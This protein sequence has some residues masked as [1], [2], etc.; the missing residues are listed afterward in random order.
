MVSVCQMEPENVVRWTCTPEYISK[1][2]KG[3]KKVDNFYKKHADI[4]AIPISSILN[5]VTTYQIFPD[6]LKIAK[7]V[8]L[9]SRTIFSLDF[10]PKIIEDVINQNINKTLPPEDE[11]QMAYQKRRS[12]ELCVAIG[13]HRVEMK[14]KHSRECCI[15]VDFDCKKAFDS[16]NWSTVITKFQE[17]TGCGKLIYN[18]LDKR[19]YIFEGRLGF[20]DEKMGRGTP[21]GTILGPS[22]FSMF[23]STDRSMNLS[24]S[25]WVWP[26][27]FS[28][29]KSPIGSMELYRN[30][31]FQRGLDGTYNWSRENFI[32]YHL[33]GK[34]RPKFFV[35]RNFSCS[36][37]QLDDVHLKMGDTVIERAYSKRQLGIQMRFFQDHEL[38]NDYGYELE[39]KTKT[40]LSLFSSRLQDLRFIWEPKFIRTAVHSYVVGNINYAAA[41]QWLRATRHDIGTVRFQYCKALSAIIGCTA[42]E[43]IG[44]QCCKL[45]SLSESSENFLKLCKMVNMPTIKD[46][47]IKSAKRLIEQWLIYEPDLFV[48]T[49]SLRQ[50]RI[51]RVKA[52][53]GTLL[54]DLFKLSQQPV[55]I[56]YPEY[57]KAKVK[58]QLGK[59]DDVYQPEWEDLLK[60]CTTQAYLVY[61]DMLQTQPGRLEQL[62]GFWIVCKSRFKCLEPTDRYKKRLDLVKCASKRPA[63]EVGSSASTRRHVKRRHVEIEIVIDCETE[64]P[65]RGSRLCKTKCRIC[66]YAISKKDGKLKIKY[67]CCENFAHRECWDYQGRNLG[68]RCSNIRHL[69]RKDRKTKEKKATVKAS[70][71]DAGKVENIVCSLCEENIPIGIKDGKAEEH[72]LRFCKAVPVTLGSKRSELF[73]IKR[74]I[75][76]SIL[77]SPCASKKRKFTSE[78]NS[79]INRQSTRPGPGRVLGAGG[80]P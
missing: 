67:P 34:K 62:R 30:G 76:V 79:E 5:V 60:K 72:L 73:V 44:L 54:W 10:W 16:T 55:N 63:C 49:R 2:I 18:Y 41:L 31:D 21:P 8:L 46:I 43:I 56:W 74:L 19:T 40:P 78:E 45:K 69:L 37:E 32:E 36:D 52:A 13:L 71:P 7:L 66:G 22:L 53:R 15:N 24:S 4:L 20:R 50:K 64:A 14:L 25:A 23:Q 51:S 9:P 77:L 61:A 65:N 42:P 35:F 3:L 12:T 48:F 17:K 38:A 58:R 70:Q 33:D 11:G 27:K 59:L 57:E 39:W 80:R 29:D 75:G 1:R 28:D 68:V 26:G 6:V 47:A